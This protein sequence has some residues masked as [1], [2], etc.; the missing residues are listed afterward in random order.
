MT[1]RTKKIISN[2]LLFIE[3]ILLFLILITFTLRI[4]ILNKNN[5]IKKLDKTNYY[6]KVYNETLDNMKYI[7]KKSGYSSEILNDI[8]SIEDIKRD[9]KKYV[10]GIYENTK[11]EVNAELMK[12][13][14]EENL[15]KY[16]EEK[17]IEV[18]NSK[19][20]EYINKIE[21]TYKNEIKLMNE[22]NDTSSYINKYINL[23][24]TLLILFIIDLIVVIIINKKIFNKQEY[25]VACFSSAISLLVT[26]IIIKITFKD[27]FIYN[28]QVTEVIKLA[29]KKSLGLN[30]LFILILIVSGILTHKYI[31]EEKEEIYE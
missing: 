22:F 6:E 11:V 21:L 25:Y 4:T 31:K 14:L 30:I 9:T 13:S 18:S 10:T 29:I 3:S 7:T 5:I 16:I 17:N 15:N 20:V 23:S 12:E 19:K 27:L 2:I 1:Y 8:L 28:N 24:N 26:S